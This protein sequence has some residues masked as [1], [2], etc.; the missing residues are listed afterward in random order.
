MSG[1]LPKKAGKKPRTIFLSEDVC[2]GYTIIWIVFVA[3]IQ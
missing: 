3:D 1:P 2:G